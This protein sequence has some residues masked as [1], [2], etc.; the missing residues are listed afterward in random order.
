MPPKGSKMVDGKWVKPATPAP[1]PPA[2][3]KSSAGVKKPSAKAKAPKKPKKAKAAST[4]V[5]A[6]VAAAAASVSNAP[7]GPT[8]AVKK[9]IPL[10]A[11][12]PRQQ[13]V[14]AT[15]SDAIPDPTPSKVP[16]TVQPVDLTGEDGD[17]PAEGGPV[18]PSSPPRTRDKGK[19]KVSFEAAT[20]AAPTI[21]AASSSTAIP[22]GSDD[23][24]DS[25]F[26]RTSFTL[27]LTC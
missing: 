26:V 6:P 20:P 18:P 19:R 10:P 16:A 9:P 22:M 15:T 11:P 13:P 25:L 17:S 3:S 5:A 4:A 7:A 2:T 12:P 27:R 1:A 14:V 21:P 8:P 23:M 24:D